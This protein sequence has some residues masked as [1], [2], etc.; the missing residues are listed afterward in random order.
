MGD[1]LV[2]MN[3][4]KIFTCRPKKVSNFN[5]L[6]TKASINLSI[7]AVIDKLLHS[8]HNLNPGCLIQVK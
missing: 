6:K 1:R 8:V 5:P 4:M 3:G 2:E 7:H